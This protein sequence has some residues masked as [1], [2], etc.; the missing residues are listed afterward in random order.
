M[1]EVSEFK[2]SP[3]LVLLDVFSADIKMK[4]FTIK[5]SH[6][7]QLGVLIIRGNSS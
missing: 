4:E 2:V 3:E 6:E 5:V 1:A 7:F